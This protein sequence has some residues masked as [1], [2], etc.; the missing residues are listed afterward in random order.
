MTSV[1]LTVGGILLLVILALVYR[2]FTLVGIAKG[3]SKNKVS[4][5]NK[6][7]AMLFPILFVLGFGAIF[8]YSGVAQKYFLPEAA[9]EHG[10][11][12]DYLFWLTMAIIGF[13]FFVTHILLF[14]FPFRYQYKESRTAYFYPHN[15]KLEIIWTIIPAI[16]M[17]I[18]VIS[19]YVV[20]NDITSPAPAEAVNIELMGKQFNWEVRYGG[21]DLELGRHDY[22]KIDGTNSMGIDFRDPNSIDD[23]ISRDI[24]LPKGKPVLLNIR[25]RDVLHSVFMPHF[26]VKMD[27]VPGMPTKFW[28]T[29]NKTTEE[30]RELLS[31]EE[32]WQE[33]DPETGEPRYKNFNYEL[34][35]TEVCGG[36]HFA[37]RKVIVVEEAADFEKWHKEQESWASKNKD[38][39]SEQGYNVLDLALSKD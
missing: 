1:L 39:L 6:V 4:T 31:K 32:V 28:F 29:P 35:C 27:A 22:K 14:W 17:T 15:D 8:W 16:V 21:N 34:A 11:E 2:I 7:N 13:A 19:G 30:M 9:S 10:S 25:A 38:Y 20:W 36:G 26:R 23:F 5:S 18:L 3:N 37:M 33:I 12:I 24:H